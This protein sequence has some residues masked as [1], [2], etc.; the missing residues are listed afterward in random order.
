ME[1]NLKE[2]LTKCLLSGIKERLQISNCKIDMIFPKHNW[3]AESCSAIQIDR[4]IA[5]TIIKIGVIHNFSSTIIKTTDTDE[6]LKACETYLN[7]FC[8]GL[9]GG[10]YEYKWRYEFPKNYKMNM[11]NPIAFMSDYSSLHEDNGRIIC[12]YKSLNENVE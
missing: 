10:R 4:G 1:V 12:Y 8:Y 9:N 6:I 2:K 5:R 11:F 3:N 7:S